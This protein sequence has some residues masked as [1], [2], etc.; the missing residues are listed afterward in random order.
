VHRAQR[1]ELHVARATVEVI[2]AA[3]ALADELTDMVL[4][5]LLD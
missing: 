5:Y 3:T 2:L 4:R 1:G